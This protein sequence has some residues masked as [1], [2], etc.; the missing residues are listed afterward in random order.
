MCKDPKRGH[1][2]ILVPNHKRQMNG[3]AILSLNNSLKDM[4]DVY[5]AEIRPKFPALQDEQLFLQSNG[6]AFKGGKHCQKAPRIQAEIRCETRS[7]CNGDKYPQ[8]DS[9]NLPPKEVQWCIF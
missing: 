4:L 2:A 8:V 7:L 6:K 3:P 5:V 9:D 1:Y